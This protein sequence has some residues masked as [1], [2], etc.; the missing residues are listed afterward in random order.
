MDK[1]R[2]KELIGKENPTILEIGCADGR[3]TQDFI[4]L[5]N[6]KL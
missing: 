4:N 6:K 3:D 2:I 1:T 5:K